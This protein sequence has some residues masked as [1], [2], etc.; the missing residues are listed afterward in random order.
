VTGL[1]LNL[2]K[3]LKLKD[4]KS[5]G[6]LNLISNPYS[7]MVVFADLPIVPLVVNSNFSP[8]LKTFR[9]VK[10]DSNAIPISS[11]FECLRSKPNLNE[12]F[13]L[14]TKYILASNCLLVSDIKL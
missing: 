4:G 13:F 9:L 10:D 11:I 2:T 8:D 5:F 7:E 14:G 1:F 6:N 12:Y 3:F